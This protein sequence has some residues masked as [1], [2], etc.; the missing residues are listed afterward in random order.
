MAERRTIETW[1]ALLNIP[2][3][4]LTMEQAMLLHLGHLNARMDAM[5]TA[6][7]DMQMRLMRIELY[8]K[9]TVPGYDPITRQAVA[10][11]ES[12]RNGTTPPS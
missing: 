6:I 10:A 9:H 12:A 8:L 5:L 4:P 7:L 11:L 3:E 1:G 2:G